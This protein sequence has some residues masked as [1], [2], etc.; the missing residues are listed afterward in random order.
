MGWH[1]CTW[2]HGFVT[3]YPKELLVPSSFLLLLEMPFVTSSFLFL[4][5]MLLFL[6]QSTARIRSSFAHESEC[7]LVVRGELRG[8]E[9]RVL[10]QSPVRKDP[11]ALSRQGKKAICLVLLKQLAS[12]FCGFVSVAQLASKW[13]KNSWIRKQVGTETSKRKET[14]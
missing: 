14:P 11:A 13:P 6:V 8:R 5:A 3:F 12:C 7:Y 1:L 9:G 10:F 4:I 2:H